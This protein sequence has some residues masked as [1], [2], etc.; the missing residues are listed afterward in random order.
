MNIG[1][2]LL[3]LSLNSIGKLSQISKPF[4]YFLW[5]TGSYQ[6]VLGSTEETSRPLIQLEGIQSVLDIGC[7]GSGLVY[8]SY[9]QG[10]TSL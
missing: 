8:A 6:V 2:L 3:F 5:I 9:M 4:V 10:D 7:G 1:W